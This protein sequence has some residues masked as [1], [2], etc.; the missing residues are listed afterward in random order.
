ML[1][2]LPP[3]LGEYGYWSDAE[4]VLD[5]PDLDDLA[6]LQAALGRAV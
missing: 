4:G 2:E 3:L 1:A 6:A 5:G